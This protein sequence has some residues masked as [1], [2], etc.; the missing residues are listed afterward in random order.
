MSRSTDD[1]IEHAFSAEQHILHTRH[2]LN[3][4]AAGRIHC[5]QISGIHHD[6][7]PRLQLILYHMTVK[8]QNAI[9]RPESFCMI[10]PSPPKIP[11]PIRFW[12]KIDRSTPASAARKPDFCT[13][14]SLPG[15]TSCATIFPGKTG[16]KRDH[17]VTA[18]CSIRVLENRLSGKHPSECFADPRRWY[19]SPSSYSGTSSSWLPSL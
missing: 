4:H 14:I 2:A 16:C 19:S 17:S 5:S 13:T 3:L 7:L 6:L 1:R 9:P 12:K 11:E 10:N 15:A 18:L 8:F